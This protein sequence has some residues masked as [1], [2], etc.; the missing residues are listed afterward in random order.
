MND[1]Q[2]IPGAIAVLVML[3]S[4]ALA[5]PLVAVAAGDADC[6]TPV[7]LDDGWPIARPEE[8][9][10]DRARLCGLIARLSAAEDNVHGVVVVRH[11]KL[12]IEKYFAGNDEP[13]GYPRGLYDFGATSRHDMR[14]ISKSVTSLLV[15]I[16]LDR[17]LIAS[18]DQPVIDFFPE[19][20]NLRTQGWD[21]ITLRNLLTMSSG[22]KWSEGGPWNPANDEWHLANDADPVKYVLQ[23]TVVAPPGT[24]WNYNGGGTELLGAIVAKVSGKNVKD[25]AREALFEPL[26]I[27]DWVWETW[28]SG[29]TAYAAG[30]RLRP[31]DAAK[32]GQLVLDKG[33]W[34]GRQVVSA[35]WIEESTG[36]HLQAV[37]MLGSIFF[38]GY[39]WW[40]GRSLA[41][42]G[43]VKWIAGIG[44]GG[45]RLFIVPDLDLV[46]MFTSGL[47]TSPRQGIAAVD[48]LYRFIVPAVGR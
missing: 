14:S 6:G 35:S 42:H 26:G 11:G 9:G 27:H 31:R 20:A 3:A 23:R 21:K 24:V 44:L 37:G 4:C 8:A 13:W 29:T 32:I 41:P 45:Q 47:Y 30:L 25:F 7:A 38:Y 10:F 40:L 39:Q 2:S 5:H 19:H 43:E 36:P 46:V 1:R 34:N 48:A 33:K 28:T 12:V 17:K 18:V 22:L 15:G 16:A